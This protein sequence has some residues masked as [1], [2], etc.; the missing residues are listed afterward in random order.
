[1][2]ATSPTRPRSA[3][4]VALLA[5]TIAGFGAAAWFAPQARN[6]D[7]FS[8]PAHAQNL[9]HEAQQLPQK[10]VGFADIVEKVK[11]AVIAVRVKVE[12]MAE[13]GPSDDEL[14]S[15]RVPRSSAFSNG[16]ACPRT[17]RAAA[18]SS[19]PAKAQASSSP[20]TGTPSPTI[21]LCRTRRLFK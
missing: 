15:R 5:T 14:P 20:P 2:N 6:A 11:P 13:A 1:M 19:S 8:A 7:F 18:T 16:S 3:R 4:R 10:P 17:A 21:M 9:T 12:G